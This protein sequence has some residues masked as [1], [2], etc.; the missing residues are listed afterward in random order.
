MLCFWRFWFASTHI[1]THLL[2]DSVTWFHLLNVK[3]W[4]VFLTCP[5]RWTHLLFRQK[6]SIFFLLLS[7]FSNTTALFFVSRASLFL[8]RLVSRPSYLGYRD[9]C[10]AQRYVRQGFVLYAIG[11]A[12]LHPLPLASGCCSLL[13]LWPKT[14]RRVTQNTTVKSHLSHRL[15]SLPFTSLDLLFLPCLSKRKLLVS[16]FTLQSPFP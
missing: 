11:K 6:K 2:N 14:L 1:S 3:S 13:F 5:H 9:D 12:L 10:C 8:L 7:P 15:L 16:I 4:H